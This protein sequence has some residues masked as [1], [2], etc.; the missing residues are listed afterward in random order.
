MGSF[1]G[2]DKFRTIAVILQSDKEFWYKINLRFVKSD[3]CTP[4]VWAMR[5]FRKVFMPIRIR[6]Q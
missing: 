3:P 6:H 4:A 5:S 1:R 2:L